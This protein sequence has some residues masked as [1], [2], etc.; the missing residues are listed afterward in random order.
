MEILKCGISQPWFAIHGHWVSLMWLCSKPGLSETYGFGGRFRMSFQTFQ[1]QKN[2]HPV[3][4]RFRRWTGHFAAKV[5]K[6][7]QGSLQE[8]CTEV[9]AGFGHGR[10][11]GGWRMQGLSSGFQVLI[12]H[13]RVRIWWKQY[14]L[15]S[16]VRNK[17]LPF[18]GM[19]HPLGC[20]IL[21][22]EVSGFQKVIMGNLFELPQPSPPNEMYP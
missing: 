9:S 6:G 18:S 7:P 1:F 21:H 4:S 11:R 19:C 2:L 17:S 12:E 20:P 8:F 3:P 14:S 16:T 5:C 22:Y 10:L 13:R 15:H